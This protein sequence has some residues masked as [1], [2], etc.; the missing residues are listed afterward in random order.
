[1][2]LIAL[3]LAFAPI[4]AHADDAPAPK[5]AKKPVVVAPIEVTGKRQVPV[6]IVIPRNPAAAKAAQEAGGAHLIEAAERK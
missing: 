1:M 6:G 3:L 2:R 4:L 5:K